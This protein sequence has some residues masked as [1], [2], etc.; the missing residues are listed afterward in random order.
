[1]SVNPAVLFTAATTI[2]AGIAPKMQPAAIQIAIINSM[3][4][5][6]VSVFL[7]VVLASLASF[8]LAKMRFAG[9]EA[10]FYLLLATLIVPAQLTYIP[11]PFWAALWMLV[12]LGAM[13]LGL[14]SIIRRRQRQSVTPSRMAAWTPPSRDAKRAGRSRP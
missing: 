10:I 11:A 12:S 9:R 3:I 13:V 1:M 14:R 4:V 5:S 7:T 8:P 6:V 2:M